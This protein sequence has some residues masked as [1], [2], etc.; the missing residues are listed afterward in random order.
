MFI[1]NV[2]VFSP[3]Q[4]IFSIDLLELYIAVLVINNTACLVFLRVLV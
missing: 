3:V 1:T 4:K 2:M